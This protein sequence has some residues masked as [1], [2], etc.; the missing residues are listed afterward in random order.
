MPPP[1]PILKH[2]LRI[3]FVQTPHFS[4]IIIVEK[5]LPDTPPFWFGTFPYLN[6]FLKA[7]HFVLRCV[8]KTEIVL[9][10]SVG[11]MHPII[12]HLPSAGWESVELEETCH[13]YCE[14]CTLSTPWSPHTHSLA[15]SRRHHSC[16]H[17]RGRAVPQQSRESQ[18]SKYKKM[19]LQIL[20]LFGLIAILLW[21]R[22]MVFYE[23][24]KHF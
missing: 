20:L 4:Q 5:N 7:S 23:N 18:T 14:Q 2:A 3:F 1:R 24:F 11:P 6:N 21:K 17:W 19:W 22:Y 10:L 12:V 8:H 15:T 16:E 13:H 9:C